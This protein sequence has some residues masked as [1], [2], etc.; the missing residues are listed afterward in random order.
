MEYFSGILYKNNTIKFAG[1]YMELEENHP[2]WGF[3]DPERQIWSI[4]TY[5]DISC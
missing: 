1:K 2:R 4:S 3:P 5:V